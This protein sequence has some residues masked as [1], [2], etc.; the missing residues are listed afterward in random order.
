MLSGHK[1][2][3]I[4]TYITQTKQTHNYNELLTAHC[5]PGGK[6]NCLICSL[7]ADKSPLMM[8]ATDQKVSH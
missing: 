5:L 8:M 3:C 7:L 1:H 4:C 2:L 6:K